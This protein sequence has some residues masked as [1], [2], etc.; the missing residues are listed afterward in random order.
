MRTETLKQLLLIAFIAFLGIIVGSQLFVFFPGLLGAVTL[1]ILF[2][3]SFFRLTVI[4]KWRPGWTAGLYI[5]GSIIL[6]A[7]A[8]TGVIEILLPKFRTI[9]DNRVQLTATVSDLSTKLEAISP[10]LAINKSQLMGIV[11]NITSM[12][13]GFL[14]ATANT[15]TNA[16]I[17]FFILYYMLVQGKPME[18]VVQKYM[19]LGNENINT[20]W[21][22]TRSM[23]VSNAIGI[24]VLAASQALV[25]IIGYRI[26]G[27][28]EYIVWGVLTGIFSVVPLVGCMLVWGP[29][30]IYLYA[31]GHGGAAAGLAIY[32]FIITGGIDNVLRFTILKRLGD[33]HPIITALG[34]LVGVPIFGFMGFIFGPLIISYLL[35]MVKIYRLE[36][37]DKKTQ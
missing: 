10:Q 7:A 11:Q 27:V 6:F 1:Y 12:I 22:A 30:C 18:S 26:F 19:P 5:L 16:V 13:P 24:P 29:L 4:K 25:A 37:P 35:L 3:P 36:F 28:E 31:T 14:N 8:L 20:I 15:L 9:I 32:S 21:E 2:R 17:A 23:V 34:I 33:V